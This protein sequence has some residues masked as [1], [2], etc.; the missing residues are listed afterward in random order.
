MLRNDGVKLMPMLDCTYTQAL[1]TDDPRPLT[2]ADGRARR[3]ADDDALARTIATGVGRLPARARRAPL[4]VT[5]DRPFILR[6][7]PGD[8]PADP[9]SSRAPHHTLTF[10]RPGTMIRLHRMGM[11]L[12]A[13]TAPWL[14]TPSVTL[15]QVS[16]D[17]APVV[18]LEE[19]HRRASLADPSAVAARGEIETATW[20][21]R[22]A[23]TDLVAP[24]IT[25]ESNYTHFSDPFFN[26]GTGGVSSSATNATL[27]ASY[28]VLGA[29][30]TGELRRARASLAQA[31]ASET[32]TR[33]RVALVTDAAYYAVL[34]D[35]ELARV[36]SDRLRRAEEQLD[37][38]RARVV[39]GDAISSDS[40]QLVLE[41]NR[42]R[43]GQIRADS[44]L[45]TSRLRL[46]RRIGLDGPA[47][48]VTIETTSP[49]PLPLSLADAVGELRRRGPEIEAARA[50]ERSAAATVSAE[51]E[52]YLP[53]IRVGGTTG[54]YDSQL[55][56]SALTRS[57]MTVTVSLPIWNAGQRELSIARAR[58]DRD[59]ARAARA[60]RER[61]AG[62]QMAEAFHGYESARAA[63]EL[64]RVGVAAAAENFRVQRVRY[65]EGATTILEL[66]E[67]QVALSEADAAL[68]Q[69]R[70]AALLALARIE[71]LLGRR[72]FQPAR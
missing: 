11:A 66:L 48:A 35:R 19:A 45:A 20:A 21:R 71:S 4:H 56:P 38:A 46:G 72:V 15:A 32:A 5:T 25:G 24:T 42:A 58:A 52:A 61:A 69:S 49:P 67:A 33:F 43:L 51:R 30:K 28:T 68:V 54:T 55:F 22:A 18:T 57:Q 62:E 60:D 53:E 31:E 8:R 65:A 2:S 13:A 64:A 10:Q 6:L 70:Y 59:A 50:A 9:G 37:V 7:G 36:A 14:A 23:F 44:A 17:S 1:A 3:A 39:A 26:V 40:L 29:G 34:A 27:S 47:E 41:V 16:R 12:V 63:I